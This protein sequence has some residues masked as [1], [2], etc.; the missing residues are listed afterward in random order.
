MSICC[1][2]IEICAY[3]LLCMHNHDLNIR[4]VLLPGTND[5]ML[6]IYSA[7]VTGNNKELNVTHNKTNHS[8]DQVF[9]IVGQKMFDTPT[10]LI[11]SYIL[12]KNAHVFLELA[13]K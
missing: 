9:V 7:L 4:L 12:D 11:F 10:K 2:G 6:I 13:P 5:T 8:L 1:A 3:V